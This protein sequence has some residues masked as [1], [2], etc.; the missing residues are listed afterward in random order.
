ME[1]LSSWFSLPVSSVGRWF[2]FAGLGWGLWVG[3]V[4]EGLS[5]ESPSEE[6]QENDRVPITRIRVDADKNAIP[7]RIGDTVAVEG[8]V[9]GG[10]GK[11]SE[12][13]HFSI[14]DSTAGIHVEVAGTT[15][16]ERGD[17]VHVAG[18]VD[19]D[20]GLTTLNA[21]D[22]EAVEADS[23]VPP[24]VPLTVS[25]AA[26]EP[27]E[28]QLVQVRA[29]VSRKGSNQGGNYL[30]LTDRGENGASSILTVF[31]ANRH[32]ARIPLDRFEAGDEIEVTGVLGQFDFEAPYTEY[33]Q[34][35]P[36][37]ASDLVSLE[38]DSGLQVG[39]FILGGLG[40]LALIAVLVLR[41]AVK[42]RTKQLNESRARFRRLAEA[43]SEGIIIHDDGKIIDTNTALAELVGSDREA[44]IGREVDTLLSAVTSSPEQVSLNGTT[45][46]PA[47]AEID[48]ED[49]TTIPV[50]FE[51][52][53]VTT[54]DRRV[55]VV[56]L[57][58]ISKRKEWETEILL[59][60]EE[61]EQMAQLKSNLLN[62]MSHELRTPITSITGYAE[63]LMDEL[64]GR[65]RK[66]AL[67]IR[68]GAERLSGTLQSVLEL[69]Q[70]ESNTLDVRIQE[71]SVA[72]VVQKAVGTHEWK[73]HDK[74]LSLELDVCEDCV[75]R[76]DRSLLYR[77][78]NNLVHNAIKFTEEGHVRVSLE[79][80]GRGIRIAVK[81]T[82]IGIDP[83][84]RAQ[85]FDPFEQESQGRARAYEGAGLG[86]ALTK[87][88]VDLLGGSIEVESTK[89]EGST[90][91]V[92]LPSLE[93]SVVEGGADDDA[94]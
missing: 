27:Y 55:S 17:S 22:V 56:V 70:I 63:L 46:A 60:K 93:E 51:E 82:G 32:L 48:L 34:I 85:L 79:R 57:R 50:E 89:R 3:G 38:E 15:R 42:R 5:Q 43:T 18:V 84:F 19:Q 81:D 12:A 53:T 16:V 49:G 66:F 6:L 10:F 20:N 73:A 25:A 44:L 52:K 90:F 36:R 47:E 69:A 58:D 74:S 67:R 71:V 78:V 23:L 8:R 87:R 4:G 33:Y 11:L 29:Q 75:L 2:L 92:E 24:P 45:D 7:D 54:G 77:I 94:G 39:L 68:K 76:T 59:A 9:T 40:G 62:N 28:G 13:S 31:V 35:F 26:G 83:G 88:M 1:D 91:V 80:A 72:E 86:L 14:Q 65:Y 21:L 64:D 30:M 61:A 41:A 37:E